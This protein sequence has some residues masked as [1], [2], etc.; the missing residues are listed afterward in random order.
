MH[1][2]LLLAAQS[3]HLQQGEDRISGN[4]SLLT[5]RRTDDK[6]GWPC[7]AN[8]ETG[9]GCDQQETYC[10]GSC[11]LKCSNS[12]KLWSTWEWGDNEF[13]CWN[14][15]HFLRNQPA[16]THKWALIG[17]TTDQPPTCVKYMLLEDNKCEDGYYEAYTASTLAT[18]D[19][20]SAYVKETIDDG[21]KICLEKKWET[22]WLWKDYSWKSAVTPWQKQQPYFVED[23]ECSKE[24]KVWIA[25]KAEKLGKKRKC[26]RLRKR[27]LFAGK[28]CNSKRWQK[29]IMSRKAGCGI[30]QCRSYET[31]IF[32]KAV[33]C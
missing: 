23:E 21:T 18:N 8:M 29:D 1:L 2:C 3:Q 27:R 7:L 11:E 10:Y 9:D 12:V 19:E 6:D 17:P 31:G 5:R 14:C 25:E 22:G 4:S 30:L 33:K 32:Y 26:K 15:E 16:T 28:C 13:K 20:K 24:D